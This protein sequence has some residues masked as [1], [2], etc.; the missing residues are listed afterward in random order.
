MTELRGEM[1]LKLLLK[2]NMIHK[3]NKLLNGSGITV[4]EFRENSPACEKYIYTRFKQDDKSFIET[5][6]PYVYR[7]SGLNLET[8]EEIASHLRSLYKYFSKEYINQWCMNLSS[9]VAD[10]N[11]VFAIFLRILLGAHCK[12]ITQKRFPQNNN[13]Q[14]IFQK[15]KDKGYVLSI[16]RG[17][18][19]ENGGETRYWLLPIPLT[20]GTVYETMSD[21]FKAHVIEI[22][23]NVDVYENKE[24]VGLIPD[25]KFSEIRWDES[26]PEDNPVDMPEE[27]VKAKFQM[28]TTQRNQQK[29][30]VCRHCYKTGERGSIFGLK[31]F[32]S[33]TA[34]WDPN[35]PQRGKLAEQGCI[36]C[37]WYDIQKWR[38]ELQKKLV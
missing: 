11:S 33:G 4:I 3:I 34:S 16:L 26:V 36:G 10:D 9:S 23:G 27:K 31:F 1:Q 19:N 20:F 25:H 15:I 5:M 14:K 30:E 6:V 8:A 17:R 32:Y 24:G 13:P 2:S 18:K 29:R 7:R 28:L 12:E 21:E 38:L 22:L 35:I 37:P